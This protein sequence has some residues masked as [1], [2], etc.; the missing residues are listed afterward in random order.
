MIC[1]VKFQEH[2]SESNNELILNIKHDKESRKAAVLLIQR[3]CQKIT[4]NSYLYE[5]FT[6]YHSN[7]KDSCVFL[8]GLF[9]ILL[10]L[11]KSCRL[12]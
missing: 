7:W 10:F 6:L 1:V 11:R 3:K 12:S 5:S 2:K 4:A 8:C 9:C